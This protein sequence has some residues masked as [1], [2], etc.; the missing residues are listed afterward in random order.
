MVGYAMRMHR[1]SSSNGPFNAVVR[2]G[3][4]MCSK[5]DERAFYLIASHKKKPLRERRGSAFKLS[6]EWRKSKTA[7]H[8]ER[9]GSFA[10]K[11]GD[12]WCVQE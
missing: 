7:R 1:S 3:T 10:G 9:S 5:I 11:S 4:M 2:C 8:G 6:S 12:H